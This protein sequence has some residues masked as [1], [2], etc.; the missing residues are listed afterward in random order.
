MY[1]YSEFIFYRNDDF[2]SQMND[3]VSGSLPPMLTRTNA[4]LSY[5]ATGPMA[6]PFH[7][8]WSISH[9]AGIFTSSF[10]AA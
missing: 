5:T 8:H 7:P 9:P 6:L 2:M 4:C 10:P 3:M 1:G